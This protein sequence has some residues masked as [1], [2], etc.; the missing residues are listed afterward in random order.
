MVLP[1]VLGEDFVDKVVGIVL[2]HFDFLKNDAALA[3]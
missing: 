1:K 3:T 2:V